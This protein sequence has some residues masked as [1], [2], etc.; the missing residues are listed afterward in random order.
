MRD[1]ALGAWAL[2]L[3]VAFLL[4]GYGLQTSLLGLRGSAEGFATTTIGVVMA[5]YYAGFLAG[6]AIAPGMVGRVGHVRAFGALASI[7]SAAVLIHA[8]V[9]EPTTWFA[10]RVVT[11]FCYAGLYIVAES[12][13]NDRATNETRGR[14][15]GLYMA[16]Q[17]ASIALGQ[18]LLTVADVQEATLFIIGSVAVSLGVV[19]ILLTRSPAPVIETPVRLG[20]M[21]LLRVSPLAVV[22]VVLVGASQGGFGSLAA[23]YGEQSGLS[24]EAIAAFIAA[25]VAGGMAM[26]WGVGWIADRVDRRMT[27]AGLGMVSAAAALAFLALPIAWRGGAVFL[28]L[29]VVFGG[30]L[31]PLYS[32]VVAHANDRLNKSQMVGASASLMLLYGIGAMSGPL[33]LS[34]A[35]AVAGPGGFFLALAAVM[36]GLGVYALWRTTRR[37]A[38]DMDSHAAMMSPSATALAVAVATEEASTLDETAEDGTRPGRD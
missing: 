35:M 27:I 4:L 22:G 25:T 26:Q 9:I 29:A 8:V 38:A 34:L 30:A 5:G 31:Y 33:V 23:V 15:L 10:M 13:L 37:A 12:W 24:V 36:A 17:F 2:L 21:A 3:G 14:L 19:P 32:V 18:A 20:P 1:I 16:V 11:G 7:A 28:A 6:S